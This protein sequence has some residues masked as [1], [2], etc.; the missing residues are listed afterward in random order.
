MRARPGGGLCP[1]AF[2]PPR[3]RSGG[4]RFRLE[5]GRGGDGT[6]VARYPTDPDPTAWLGYVHGALTRAKRAGQ[7]AQAFS[8]AGR[9]PGGKPPG[10]ER[11]RAHCIDALWYY[12]HCVSSSAPQIWLLLAELSAEAS[13][14]EAGAG[15]LR[16]ALSLLPLNSL[17]WRSLLRLS[18]PGW[19]IGSDVVSGGVSGVAGDARAG[20]VT[21]QMI[22]VVLQWLATSAAAGH[23][24]GVDQAIT[25][26]TTMMAGRLGIEMFRSAA[27]GALAAPSG[28]SEASREIATSAFPGGLFEGCLTALVS[29]ARASARILPWRHVLRWLALGRASPLDAFTPLFVE[30]CRSIRLRDGYSVDPACTEEFDAVCGEAL[31]HALNHAESAANRSSFREYTDAIIAL[32]SERT[33]LLRASLAVSH[34]DLTSPCFAPFSEVLC[35][36]PEGSI[37][38]GISADDYGDLVLL[39]LPTHA[40][41]WIADWGAEFPDAAIGGRNLVSEVMRGVSDILSRRV[42]V[43]SQAIL[44]LDLLRPEGA[45]DGGMR[46]PIAHLVRHCHGVLSLFAVLSA[47]AVLSGETSHL[48]DEALDAMRRHSGKEFATCVTKVVEQYRLLVS[49]APQAAVQRA[50]RV[51]GKVFSLGAQEAKELILSVYYSTGS[52]E[53]YQSLPSASRTLRAYLRGRPL[54]TKVLLKIYEALPSERVFV[55]LFSATTEAI[56]ETLALIS[57]AQEDLFRVRYP[58]V[59]S[60]LV[61]G[62]SSSERRSELRPLELLEHTSASLARQRLWEAMTPVAVACL[63]GPPQGPKERLRQLLLG[64][65]CVMRERLPL[66]PLAKEALALRLG[67]AQYYHTFGGIMAPGDR[68]VVT[69]SVLSVDGAEYES[70]AFSWE[71]SQMAPTTASFTGLEAILGEF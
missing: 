27:G 21:R 65:E 12:I 66:C 14:R 42:N 19:R 9:A 24:P 23:Q 52:L 36:V 47:R 32:L 41:S 56:V 5:G 67:L 55:E 48:L 13:G 62:I 44:L 7:A 20:E 29:Y 58:A 15:V 25:E 37:T 39:C 1:V 63:N 46:P 70:Y 4:G 45:G 57:G 69:P 71:E 68:P 51:L 2:K 59:L 16:Q 40:L 18:G 54:D 17:L 22:E 64:P 10:E 31:G 8:A 61:C 50:G 11:V 43:V 6:A 53:V 28:A 26:L 38:R 49:T 34:V 35:L 30:G 60:S 33:E 3:M